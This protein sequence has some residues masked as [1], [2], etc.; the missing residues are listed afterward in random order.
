MSH[1]PG[2]K[3]RRVDMKLELQSHADPLTRDGMPPKE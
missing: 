3:S 1:H 2:R